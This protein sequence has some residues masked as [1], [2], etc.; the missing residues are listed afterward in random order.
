MIEVQIIMKT[1][2]EVKMVK[3][4]IGNYIG[5]KCNDTYTEVK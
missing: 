2:N 4:Y 5:R 1:S 3:R